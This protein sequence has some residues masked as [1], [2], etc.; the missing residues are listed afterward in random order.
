M[1][2]LVHSRLQ[3]GAGVGA[4]AGLFAG[5]QGRHMPVR[6][7]LQHS[8]SNFYVHKRL[9]CSG[10]D[11]PD[12]TPPARRPKAAPRPA[13]RAPCPAI[14]RGQAP[15]SSPGPGAREDEAGAATPRQR[16]TRAAGAARAAPGPGSRADEDD[17]P[18]PDALCEACNIASRH[19]TYT[20]HKRYYCASRHDPPPR[21][22]AP[23][24]TPA[25]SAPPVRT[26]RR[27]KLY[28]LHAAGP[29]R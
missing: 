12:D 2:E 17:D 22:P 24:G 13:S 23:A 7:H 29:P 28:E 18:P 19:E 6:H 26:R 14:R 25:P 1:S 5:P 20:V 9:Y 27:R 11:A 15:R 10:A 21:R 3:A 4:P 8:I 16:L